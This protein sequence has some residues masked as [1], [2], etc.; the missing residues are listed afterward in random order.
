MYAA[1]KEGGT[2]ILNEPI[3][4]NPGNP[5]SEKFHSIKEQQLIIRT[6]ELYEKLF[7]LLNFKIVESKCIDY[8]GASERLLWLVL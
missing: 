2:I 3:L 8:E 4:T 1:L 6:Y 7:R 5:S